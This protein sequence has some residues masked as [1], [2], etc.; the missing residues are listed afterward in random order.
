MSSTDIADII[1]NAD[2][3]PRAKEQ[4]AE[5][6]D[7]WRDNYADEDAG[8]RVIESEVPWFLWV[9]DD[10]LLVG[11]TD[12]IAT[13]EEGL[14]MCEWKTAKAPTRYWTESR[15]LESIEH[16]PQL[17]IYAMA[18][19]GATFCWR[20]R[21][22]SPLYLP[23]PRMLV[24]AAVKT[25]PP[26]FWPRKREMG[27]FPFDRIDTEN[28]L[29][30]I[31]AMFR[32][33][34]ANMREPGPWQLTGHWCERFGH[35][36][37]FHA[38]CVKHAAPQFPYAGVLSGTDPG[39]HALKIALANARD[40]TNIIVLSQTMYSTAANCLELYRL[41][42]GGRSSRAPIEIVTGQ[43]FHNAIAAHYQS[44]GETS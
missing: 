36:C 23:N 9:G 13:D 21:A 39:R 41:T 34:R 1:I 24:R 35:V 40:D 43:L 10:D 26:T 27:V 8:M 22:P 38:Q 17:A 12:L 5:L 15:W 28:T 37:E 30:A 4:A 42:Q 7:A 6:F 32:A 25:T 14:L 20:N 19:A 16:G 44:P 31:R 3:P 29:N 33:I 2:A 18:Q 11:V